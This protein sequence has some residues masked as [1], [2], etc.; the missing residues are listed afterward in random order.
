MEFGRWSKDQTAALT[1]LRDE[2]VVVEA[3]PTS[4]KNYQ[5]KIGK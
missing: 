4:A 1:G 5:K 2:M 3:T